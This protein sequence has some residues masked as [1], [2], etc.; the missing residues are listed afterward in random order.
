M[1]TTAS[2]SG[3]KDGTHTVLP[4]LQNVRIV[5]ESDMNYEKIYFQFIADRRIKE[6][7]VTG[8][9]EKHHIIPRSLGGSDDASNLIRLSYE[10]HVRA[11]VLLAHAYGGDQWAAVLLIVSNTSR[12]KVPT[13]RMVRLSAIAR[14]RANENQTGCGNY[15]FGKTHSEETKSFLSDL[16]R[17]RY[18]DKTNH[19]CFGKKLS[20]ETRKKISD[21]TTGRVA[22][23]KGK[24][25]SDEQKA[26]LSTVRTGFKSS[27]EAKQRI[28]YAHKLKVYYANAMGLDTSAHFVQRNV[29]IAD[30]RKW[31]EQN[32]GMLK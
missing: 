2:F 10:D 16:Q 15:F 24:P 13:K 25:M 19:P 32:G 5:S 20:E 21:K 30:A 27:E 31:F 28:A 17:A 23:N 22:H 9:T 4:W 26:L 12:R 6:H 14:Q 11:H 18:S 29:K 3:R 7:T 8:Y 1:K